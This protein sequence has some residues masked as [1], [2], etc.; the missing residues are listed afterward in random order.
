[1][2]NIMKDE[3]KPGYISARKHAEQLD[4]HTDGEAKWYIHW[5]RVWEFLNIKAYA[6]YTVY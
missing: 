5:Q 6:Y 2:K 3:K 4:S 1:M